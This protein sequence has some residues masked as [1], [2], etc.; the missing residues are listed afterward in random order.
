MALSLNHV[1]V[2]N[3]LF[4]SVFK[5]IF[6]NFPQEQTKNKNDKYVGF[7][8]V[9][10]RNCFY[11]NNR[12]LQEKNLEVN[13]KQKKYF[14]KIINLLKQNN[15][16]FLLIEVPVTKEYYSK[17]TKKENYDTWIS[18]YGEHIDFNKIIIQ[19]DSL[20]F[21]DLNHLNQSGVQKFNFELLILI[22]NKNIF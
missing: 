22:R 20:D 3:T 9:E 7:G 2:Y 17:Y 8:Y 18:N 15:N 1:K 13:E 12:E 4:Y 14:I 10:R 11:S 6:K 19:N 5:N 21:Y 16:K